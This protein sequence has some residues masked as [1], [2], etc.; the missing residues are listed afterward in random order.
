MGV[1]ATWGTT[2]HAQETAWYPLATGT[3]WTFAALDGSTRTRSVQRDTVVAGE[4]FR[5]VEDVDQDSRGVR[6]G[7]RRFVVRYDATSATW[8]SGQG[9]STALAPCPLPAVPAES[10]SCDDEGTDVR[11]ASVGSGPVPVGD[12]VLEVETLTLTSRV[13]FDIIVY[14]KGVGPIFFTEEGRAFSL[15]SRAQDDLE[16]ELEAVRAWPSPTA[17]PFTLWYRADT[18]APLAGETLDVLGRRVAS[19]A[20]PPAPAGRTRLLNLPTAAGVYVVR[21]R[22]A[23]GTVLG[24]TRVVRVR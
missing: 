24:E 7:T 6:V 20:L 23:D 18:S 16:D 8:R 13:G 17:G 3:T 1:V 4:S 15:T 5:V 9:R 12:D 21:V 22:R 10:V 19:F 11:R 2:P 14:A